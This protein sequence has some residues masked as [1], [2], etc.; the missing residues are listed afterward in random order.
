M[1]SRKKKDSK[2]S[3]DA[4][5][6]KRAPKVCMFCQNKTLPS[7]TDSQTLRKFMSDRSRILPKIRTGACSKHQRKVTQE[8]KYARHLSILPF[9]NQI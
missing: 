5:L 7:F 1:D 6:I 2:R 9:V 3:S 8:I 4:P